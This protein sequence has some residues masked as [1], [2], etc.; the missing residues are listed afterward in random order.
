M[1]GADRQVPGSLAAPLTRVYAEF[2]DYRCPQDLW[3]C[4]QCGPEFS[5]RDICATPL[6]LVSFSQLEAVHV[7]SLDDDTLRYFF[8]RLA[9]LL[10]VDPWQAF[11]FRLSRLKGRLLAW[12]PAESAAVRQFTLAAWQEFL[13]AYPASLG[14]LSDSPSMLS[15]SDWCDVPLQPLLDGWQS[16]DTPSAARHLADLIDH[17]C[18]KA[19]PFDPAISAPVLAW[20]RQ[21]VIG[22]RLEN[23]FF[24]AESEEVARELSAAHELWSVCVSA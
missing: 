2:A 13:M 8:P 18:T 3:V 17:V 14:Y 1:T 5:A 7:M 24:T 15:F 6:R 12:K 19:D 11:S 22:E 21:P 23:A 20:L 16:I 9:E 10:L 4:P